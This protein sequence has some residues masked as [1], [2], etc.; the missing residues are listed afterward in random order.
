M[1]IC[2]KADLAGCKSALLVPTVDKHVDSMT[3]G[4]IEELKIRGV[5]QIKTITMEEATSQMTKSQEKH[6]GE[7]PT[8]QRFLKVTDK[9]NIVQLFC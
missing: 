2:V 3:I 5:K 1:E 7:I 9:G 4:A 6:H 8:G